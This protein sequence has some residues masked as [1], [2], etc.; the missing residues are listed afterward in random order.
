MTTED[1]DKMM[2]EYREKALASRTRYQRFVDIFSLVPITVYFFSMVILVILTGAGLTA[3][4]HL[5]RPPLW[6][7]S[8]TL[9]PDFQQSILIHLWFVNPMPTVWSQSPWNAA[10]IS[11]LIGLALFA[12]Y[13]VS[14]RIAYKE[15]FYLDLGFLS[16]FLLGLILM[17][18]APNLFST[19]YYCFPGTLIFGLLAIPAWVTIAARRPFTHQFSDRVI[20]PMIRELD[21]YKKIH[22]I[23][24]SVWGTVFTIN[25]ILG[26][27]TYY[28]PSTKPLWAALFFIPLFFLIY[29]WA[30]TVHFP[31]WYTRRV[32]K[33]PL[34]KASRPLPRLV[35]VVG[36]F[37]TLFAV[38][39][40]LLNIGQTSYILGILEIVVAIILM[41]AGVGIV[42]VKKWGWYLTVGGLASH[43]VLLWLAYVFPNVGL[44]DWITSINNF[45]YNLAFAAPSEN[46]L[47]LAV[48]FSG[49][50]TVFL[51]YLFPKR[52]HYI[53]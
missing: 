17:F 10:A 31:A 46:L 14:R 12:V 2:R 16:F 6:L 38:L 51:C 25:A 40:L 18:V 34:Q 27:L 19:L 52:N 24:A 48:I 43:I 30:F 15:I 39:V 41:A 53:F 7:G 28:V 45:L 29:A 4:E 42:L 1:I 32:M 8:P 20:P 13:F 37:L 23:I 36:V 33:T 47:F 49:I 3:L 5:L 21:V 9:L 22:I 11:V 26:Y 44:V 35:R 50:S